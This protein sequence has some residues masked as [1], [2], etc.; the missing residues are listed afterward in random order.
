MDRITGPIRFAGPTLKDRAHISADGS[1]RPVLEQALIE[2]LHAG[3]TKILE[4]IAR[5]NSLPK[6]LDALTQFI[7]THADGI[8]CS[9][10]FVDAEFRIRPASAPTLPSE[11]NG[12]LDGVPIFPYIGPCG[13]AAYLKQQ[14]I[15]E[16]IEADDRW[17]DGFRS[18]TRQHGLKRVR[19]N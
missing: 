11:Y 2:D 14:V 7:E 10:S 13:M 19:E 5:G 3:E 4:M 18:L 17:S 6:V 12:K 8:H 15:S 16:N 1:H 9:I